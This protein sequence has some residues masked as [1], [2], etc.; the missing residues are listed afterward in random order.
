MLKVM[1]WGIVKLFQLWRNSP[2]LARLKE[3]DRD[4]DIAQLVEV[5]TVQVP[6]PEFDS[7]NPHKKAGNDGVHFQFPSWERDPGAYGQSVYSGIWWAPGQRKTLSG[8]AKSS[9][10]NN[11]K[12]RWHLRSDTQCCP[13]CASMCTPT[14]LYTQCF[15]VIWSCTYTYTHPPPNIKRK[16]KNMW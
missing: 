10:R 8:K 15:P 3:C 2:M 14:H 12:G 7:Q 13:V 6:G 5:L 9:K 1:K 4:G 11:K 16:T